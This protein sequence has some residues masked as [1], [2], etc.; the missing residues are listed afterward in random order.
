MDFCEPDTSWKFD[1]YELEK[2]NLLLI[3]HKVNNEIELF[4]IMVE[5]FSTFI[6]MSSGFLVV[7][8]MDF[9]FEESVV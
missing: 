7:A 4:E 8:L 9:A 5:W 2:Y 3:I 1:P 6:E